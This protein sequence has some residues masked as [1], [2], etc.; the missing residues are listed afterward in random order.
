MG[1]HENIRAECVTCTMTFVTSLDSFNA[2]EAACPACGEK[3]LSNRGQ[4]T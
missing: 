1:D 4:L 3:K 2:Q